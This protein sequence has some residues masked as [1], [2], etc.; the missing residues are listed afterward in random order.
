MEISIGIPQL[1]YLALTVIGLA[2]AA[3]Q[4]GEPRTGNHSFVGTL[5]ATVL[6][7]SLLWWG[8]FFDCFYR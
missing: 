7:G 2:T 4:N 3:M 5:V 6:I 8:G 1:L